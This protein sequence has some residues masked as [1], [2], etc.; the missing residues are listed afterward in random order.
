MAIKG[1]N[2]KFKSTKL[3]EK[4]NSEMVK[5][6]SDV[7]AKTLN[8]INHK[9]DVILITEKGNKLISL[10]NFL[11]R[12][13]TE[14]L[15]KDLSLDNLQNSLLANSIMGNSNDIF[16]SEMNKELDKAISRIEKEIEELSG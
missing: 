4:F 6:F 12:K 7:L 10:Q 2:G 16:I 13:Q 14:K 15:K 11:V 5:S 3:L 9:E 8:S 1:E